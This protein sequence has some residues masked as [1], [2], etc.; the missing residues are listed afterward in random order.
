[1]PAEKLKKYQQKRHFDQTPEPSGKKT[2]RGKVIKNAASKK[3]GEDDLLLHFA[4]QKHEASHLHYDFRLEIDGV[5]KSWAVPKGPSL[6]PSQKRLAMQVEDHPYDYLDFEGVIPDGNYGAGTVMLW[7]YGSYLPL[8]SKSPSKTLAAKKKLE[9]QLI[10]ALK[11][12]ELKIRLFGEKLSGEFVLVKTKGSRMGENAWLLIKHKDNTASKKDLTKLGKSV[13]SGLSMK[14]IAKAGNASHLPK[15]SR[16]HKQEEANVKARNAA[17]VKLAKSAPMQGLGMDRLLSS[18]P[19]TPMPSGI[20]VMLATLVGDIFDD[21]NWAFEIKWDGYRALAYVE[22]KPRSTKPMVSLKSRSQQGFEDKYYPIKTALAHL[23]ASMV[24]DGEIVVVDKAG[25]PQFGALQRWQSEKD[26]DLQYYVFDLLWYEGKDL[27]QLPYYQ[28]RE[29]LEAV[30]NA[31]AD[32]IIRLG[33][34]HRGGGKAFFKQ[35]KKLGLE[36]VVA[37]R[38]DSSYQDGSRS[39]DWLKVKFQ[40]RQE[41]IIIGYTKEEG[42][43]RPFSALLLG[44]YKEGALSYVGKVG[45]GFKDKDL[46]EL[47]QLFQPLIRKTS[48]LDA[49]AQRAVVKKS[50]YNLGATDRQVYW[51]K[52]QLVAEVSYLEITKEGLFRQPVFKGLREDKKTADILLE[53]RRSVEDVKTDTAQVAGQKTPDS[54][55]KVPKGNKARVKSADVKKASKDKV[56][57]V[58]KK[59]PAKPLLSATEVDTSK[60]VGGR[61]LQFTHLDKLYWENEGIDKRALINYY[62]QMAPFILPYLKD[63]PQSLNRFPDGITGKHFYQKDMTELAPDWAKRYLYHSEGER[64]DK[65]FFVAEGVASLLYMV[66]LGCIDLN[67]WSSTVNSPDNPTWCILDLD[68]D[69]NKK[70][71]AA[72]EEVIVA[73]REVAEVLDSIGVQGYPKTSGASGLHIYIPLAEMYSYEQSKILAQWILT[74]VAA[75]LPKLTTLE[76]TVSKRK[77]KVYLDF[78]QNRHQATLAAPYSVR[79]QP[80]ATVSMPLDWTEVKK[81]LRREE[82]T[83]RTA[84]DRVHAVGDLF[85]PVLA[86]G[87][88]LAKVLRKIKENEAVHS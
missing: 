3:A 15:H 49:D 35:V 82:F 46:S 2:S 39:R 22:K 55:A 58:P 50:K 51:L 73:A 24:L 74:Q 57:A 18:L 42:H 38:W 7:D 59:V 45:T 33:F 68:P 81:G 16:L 4:V 25:T 71:Q 72:F 40:Q 27:R 84:L 19:S 13:K 23:G 75:R 88:D 31:S 69:K 56:A 76:R 78:L 48:P 87:I 83:I 5:L 70:G 29:L 37:K 66:N 86:K 62:Y 14:Q 53:K 67:P 80:G 41:V 77:G 21:N 8:D 61:L 6:D 32:P 60:R 17:S 20:S 12:G 34:M 36:G 63:R 65:H 10:K 85:K 64:E 9:K 11:A 30:I 47:Y 43:P 52:P 28:R 79:A 44:V 26:G 1:M 54:R